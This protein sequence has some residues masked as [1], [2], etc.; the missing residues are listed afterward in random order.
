MRRTGLVSLV[1]VLLAP[2]ALL[3]PGARADHR[4]PWHWK[5]SATPFTVHFVDSV[6]SSWD[7]TLRNAADEWS[8]SSVLDAVVDDGRSDRSV[9][10]SCPMARRAVRV[11]NYPYGATG[12]IGLSTFNLKGHHIQSASIRLNSTYLGRNNRKVTCHELGHGL[13]LAHRSVKSSCMTQGT[14]VS[15]HPDGHDYRMLEKIYRHMHSTGLAPSHE[16]DEE[17]RTV[18]IE[19]PASAL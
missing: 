17:I 4:A 3:V 7:D 5:I 18:T 19:Y 15:A 14:G 10:R 1:V 2:V 13:G 6:S 11:C 16:D 8:D 12:W 9:R